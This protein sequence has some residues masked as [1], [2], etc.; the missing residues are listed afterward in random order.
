[1]PK[2]DESG[3]PMPDAPDQEGGTRGSKTEGDPELKGA[4]ATGGNNPAEKK[5][6]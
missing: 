5:Q 3:E 4:S 2:V 1:M 6:T